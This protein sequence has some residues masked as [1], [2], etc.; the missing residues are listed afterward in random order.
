MIIKE[1]AMIQTIEIM[2]SL[3]GG[4]STEQAAA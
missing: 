1:S 2:G 4:S 3:F